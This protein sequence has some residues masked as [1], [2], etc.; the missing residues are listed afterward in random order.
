MM[1]H[2]LMANGDIYT[3]G[4]VF[5]LHAEVPLRYLQGLKAYCEGVPRQVKETDEEEVDELDAKIGRAS[6]QVQWVD[7]LVRQVKQADKTRRQRQEDEMTSPTR[8]SSLLSD[9][10][11]RAGSEALSY[12]PRSAPAEGMVRLYPPHLTETGGPAHGVHRAV[13]RQGP[14]V[15]NPGPQDVGV[16]AEEEKQVGSDLMVFSAGR[17]SGQVDQVRGEDVAFLAIAWS[18]GRVDIG[19]QVEK[20]EPRWI[21]SRV[22]FLTW[23]ESD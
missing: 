6:L 1:V 8:R 18:G 23:L 19:L 4:P 12:A 22:S 9:R 17:E 13:M 15:C 20:P 16:G 5:P 11:R 21:T 14:M 3:M 2:V 7:S 10:T